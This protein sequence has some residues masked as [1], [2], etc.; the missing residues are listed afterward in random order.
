M[1]LNTIES[2][3][4]N[5]VVRGFGMQIDE[6]LDL[7]FT[8]CSWCGATGHRYSGRSNKLIPLACEDFRVGCPTQC[9]ELQVDEGALGMNGIGNLKHE[10]L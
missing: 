10:G 3:T 2:G 7:D 6:M 1:N 9:P 5:G 8:Q 4:E